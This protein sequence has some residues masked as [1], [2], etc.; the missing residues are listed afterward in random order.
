MM[1][2]TKSFVLEGDFTLAYFVEEPDSKHVLIA[3]DGDG[4]GALVGRP[5]R[6]ETKIANEL[7]FPTDTEFDEIFKKNDALREQGLR[8]AEGEPD[9]IRDDV[10][11]RITVEVLS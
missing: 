8:P 4:D 6:L 10:K 11:L 2:E 5:E 1:A 7:D 9:L 3:G